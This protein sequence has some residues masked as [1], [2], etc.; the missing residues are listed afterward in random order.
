M[1]ERKQG[2]ATLGE[3]PPSF[4]ANNNLPST[5]ATKYKQAAIVMLAREAGEGTDME[6]REDSGGA[7]SL[8]LTTR[9][10]SMFQMIKDA[11][12]GK[13]IVLINTNYQMELGWMDDY[14]VDACLFIGCPGLTG[15]TGIVDVLTGK[16]PSGRLVSTF[17]A[18]SLS[19]PAIANACGNTATWANVDDIRKSGV[20]KDKKLETDF[21][22]VQIENIYVGYKYYETRYADSIMN[23]AGNAKSAAG[24]FFGASWDYAKEMCYPFGFGLS[25]TT[26]NQTIEKVTENDDNTYTVEVKVENKGPV[27]GKCAVQI[28]VNTPYDQYEKDNKIEKSAILFVAFDKTGVIEP[29]EDE[30]LEIEVEEYLFASYDYKNTKGYVLTAGDYYFAVGSDAHDAVNNVLAAMPG[31]YTG[32]IDHEG[33]PFVSSAKKTHKWT[34]DLDTTTY[35]YGED[36]KF[37]VTNRFDNMDINYWKD[38]QGNQINDVKYLTRS[39]WAGTFPTSAAQ[40]RLM[41]TEME[42]LLQGDYYKKPEGGPSTDIY[43]QGKSN[44]WLGVNNSIRFIDMKDVPYNSEKWDEFLDQFSL[45][46]LAKL[47]ADNFGNKPFGDPIHLPE[48]GGGDGCQ[49]V[50]PF[51]AVFPKKYTGGDKGWR[52]ACLYTSLLACTFNKGLMEFR[53]TLMANEA[54]YLDQTSI[55]TGGGN[56]HRTPFGGR[57]AEY[58]SEDANMCYFVGSIELPA[59]EKL[60]IL[61]G[62]KHFAG[63]D[64][65]T[66]REGVNTFNTEQG[67]REGA[68]RGFE[69]AIRK[70]KVKSVMTAFNRIGVSYSS[71]CYE[72]NMT[73]LREEW[74]F[75]G[76]VITDASSGKDSGYQSHYTMSITTGTDSYCLDGKAVGG[77]KVA[78]A[79]KAADDGYLLG[80]LRTAGKNITYALSRSSAINTDADT[81][82]IMPLWQIMTYVA[83]AFTIVLA[84]AALAMFGISKYLVFKSKEV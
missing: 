52:C 31:G 43:A 57:Q 73:V 75:V 39:D 61:G 5:W 35:M 8:A 4:Y 12:F 30:T 55:W 63:N 68:L 82:L 13:I 41:G 54:L 42:T 34:M 6:V 33:N 48:K 83:M 45:D 27:A 17:A 40:V 53:G 76:R 46:D 66:N 74:G 16:N 50:G 32:L 9:E 58:Y 28:Y 23:N 29:G 71:S 37:E 69:G 25:Y 19:S 21:V 7:S 70:G 26:F 14:N 36:G 10:K 72:L 78:D 20:I 38:N 2:S 59:M 51:N 77:M 47:T 65:E 11:G 62:I 64:Q 80:W 60:G 56:L 81:V 49:G 18:N 22:S 24:S 1:L 67:F 3:E 15:F 79:I 44:N 84:A